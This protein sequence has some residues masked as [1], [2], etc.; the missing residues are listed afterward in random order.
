LDIF[1]KDYPQEDLLAFAED[2]LTEDDDSP[3]TAEGREPMMVFLKTA[4][5]VMA[6]S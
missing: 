1:F 6:I 4:I 3:V 2:A 5:D